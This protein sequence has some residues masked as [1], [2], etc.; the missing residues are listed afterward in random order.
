MNDPYKRIFDISSNKDTDLSASAP[1][2]CSTDLWIELVEALEGVMAFM[3]LPPSWWHDEWS[4]VQE[5]K[6]DQAARRLEI[7]RKNVG[8]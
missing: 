5:D 3:T 1:V 2:D 7:A 6:Y 8:R 4:K